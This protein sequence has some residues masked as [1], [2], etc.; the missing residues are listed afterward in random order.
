VQISF[1]YRYLRHI[2][3]IDMVLFAIVVLAQPFAPDVPI[4]QLTFTQWTTSDGLSSSNNTDVL[5]D[6]HG[7]LWI[8]SFN[9]LMTFDAERIEIFD[10]SNTPILET[11]GFLTV[12]QSPDLSIYLGSQGSGL[13]RYNKGVLDPIES[14]ELNIPK[15]IRSVYIDDDGKVYFGGQNA[16]LFSL[17]NGEIKKYEG[18]SIEKI[19]ILS[20]KEDSK[21][22]VWVGTEGHGV[23][24]IK[25]DTIINFDLNEG[26]LSSYVGDLHIDESD[27]VTIATPRGL[28]QIDSSGQVTIIEKTRGIYVNVM[29]FDEWNSVWL[30]GE[31]GLFRYHF[32]SDSIESL[33]SIHGI[34]FVR[35]S[36]IMMDGQGSIWMTSSRSGLIN[37]KESLVFNI[38]QPELS[39][40]R[41]NVIHEDRQGRILIGTDQNHLEIWENN[42]IT[43]MPIKT[44][45]IGNGIRGIWDDPDGTLWLATYAGILKIK[46]GKETL[47]STSTGMPANTFRVI[48]K[49]R[50]DQFW[51]GTRSGGLIKFKDDQIQEIYDLDNGLSSNFILAVDEGPDGS[52]YV[53]TNGGGLTV[54]QPNG[55]FRTFHVKENDSGILIFNVDVQ[56]D[57]SAI[58]TTNT[59]PAHFDGDSIRSVQLALN[60]Q[61]STYF[62]IVWDHSDHL[63]LTTNGGIFKIEK[64]DWRD[65]LSGKIDEVPFTLINEMS[66]MSN[67]ECTGAT[68]SSIDS[69]G[70][71]YFPTL[72]GVCIIDPEKQDMQRSESV[73]QIRNIIIDDQSFLSYTQPLTIGPGINRIQFQFSL[74]SFHTIGQNRYRYQ[75]VGFDQNKSVMTTNPTVSYTNIPPGNYTF[76]VEG[77]SDGKKWS[78]I[79]ATFRFEVKPYIYETIWF[80]VVLGLVISGFLFA[81]FR[82]RISFIN[83]Q[84]T[85]LKKVNAELDR[86][87]YSASHELRS[88]LTSVLGIV[89]LAKEEKGD[90]SEYLHHIETSVN[91]LDAFIKDIIDYSRNTRLEVA[92]EL[93][94]FDQIVNNIFEDV[95]YTENFKKTDCKLENKSNKDFYSDSKR[96]KV[97]LSN[98]I[99]NAI[100]HH[101]PDHIDNPY[102]KV[103]VTDTPSG[104]KILIE[105][106]GPGIEEEHQHEIFKMFYRAT[107]RTEGSG[108]G[109]Y[110]VQETIEKL[111]GSIQLTSAPSKGTLF[112]IHLP[113]HSQE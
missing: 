60:G 96:L 51:M 105:D 40:N 42:Q 18:T 17:E 49:D 80:Y 14:D 9:G 74:L 46:N 81:F 62:D 71:L 48:I 103:T 19:T 57:G 86:F 99:N 34:N 91:R 6:H 113:N 30:G 109:L 90:I 63:W 36:S 77:S 88:P 41:A 44:D 89:S 92:H 52:I 45:L 82:W 5:S 95:S 106:N 58:L 4:K 11:D 21:G 37:I 29:L 75:L 47:F 76:Q 102:V 10:K 3:A 84:N 53:G 1:T 20:I 35:I 94:D 67:R 73:V 111:N 13:L 101:D 79:P 68:K 100:K 55:T 61:S 32:D 64:K 107:V 50:F 65:Y 31:A 78:T 23:F 59:G 25:S 70:T 15:S 38:S 24:H 33:E 98:L 93:M 83:R 72:G 22:H 56:P 8:T 87:V 110:I 54:I 39:S 97:V 112:E 66:G 43:T 7:M 27:M 16:G 26:L 28:H 108:L 104:I 2:L 12:E 69:N 85:K